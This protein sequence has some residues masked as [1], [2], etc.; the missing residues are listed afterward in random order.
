MI[1]GRHIIQASVIG[2]RRMPRVRTAVIYHF[3]SLLLMPMHAKSDFS[4][5]ASTPKIYRT[6]LPL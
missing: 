1:R 2:R 6:V 5:D 3:A 4:A